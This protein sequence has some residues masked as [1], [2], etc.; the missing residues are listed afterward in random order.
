MKPAF[1]V[2]LHR[3]FTLKPFKKAWNILFWNFSGPHPCVT[4]SFQNPLV[5]K[6]LKDPR[7]VFL[8]RVAA[9]SCKSAANFW[10]WLLLISKF[11]F[12]VPQNCYK[13]MGPS[14]TIHSYSLWITKYG[15]LLPTSM[16]RDLSIHLCP[17]RYPYKLYRGRLTYMYS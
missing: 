17:A 8:K 6:D 13:L 3:N 9:E 4:F 14:H 7:A 2:S 15:G 1:C 16:K 5:F 11:K 10:T 12:R